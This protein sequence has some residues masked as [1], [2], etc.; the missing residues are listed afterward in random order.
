MVA[1]SASIDVDLGILRE[2]LADRLADLLRIG[3]TGITSTEPRKAVDEA[4]AAEVERDIA[5]LVVEAERLGAA[6]LAHRVAGDAAGLVFALPDMQERAERAADVEAG[7]DGDDRNAGI[8]GGADRRGQRI[9]I[10]DGDDQPVRLLRDRRRRPAPP[11]SSRSKVS[12]A[13]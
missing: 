2:P 9:G 4:L 12:G 6:E 13:R 3:S 5:E 8:D 10:R 11:S 1:F 7:I